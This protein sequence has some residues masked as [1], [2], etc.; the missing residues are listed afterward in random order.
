MQGIRKD[1]YG[2]TVLHGVDLEL[3]A[4]EIH[5]LLGENGAGKSTLMNI[6]FGMPVIHSTGGFTGSITLDGRPVAIGSPGQAMALGIGMVHQEF[7]LIPGFTVAENVKLNREPLRR[8]L[9]GRALGRVVGDSLD[10][11]DRARMRADTEA[12]LARIELPLDPDTP[13]A[14]L[15]VGHLQFIE[16][17][18]EVDKTGMRVL[19]FD[20]PTAVL[21]ESEASRLLAVMRSLADAGLAILFITHRLDE[22]MSVADRVTILRDGALALGAPRSELT[23]ERI[24]ET[25]V[26]RPIAARAAGGGADATGAVREVA[27]ILEIR[28]LAVE[29]PGE[30]VRGVSLEVRRGEILGIGGLAGQGKI[31]IANGVMGL[32]AASGS[33]RFEGRELPLGDPRGARAAGLAFVSEDRRGTGL[34]LDEPLAMNIA[35]PAM[36]VRGRFLRPRRPLPR[37]LRSLAFVDRAA[38]R[39]HAEGAIAELDIRTTGPDQPVR[40]LS[41]G[42]QQK[43][44]LAA[45]L[46]TEPRLLF[47]SEP[48]RGIDIGA[49]QLVLDRLVDLN[50]D[51]LTVVM[52][53]SELAELR[54]ICHRIAIVAEGRIAGI[55]PPDA[56]DVRFG[57][58]MAGGRT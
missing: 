18:R 57:L 20:E 4:G 24:A 13:V 11:L 48:T 25:M 42:N 23:I 22:V 15:P 7:M 51:G 3:R 53:S 52:T 16:I 45:A 28:D 44:C 54:T 40:R 55:L 26:G 58:L 49:K 21:A 32:F 50:R 34:L 39:A 10:T 46:G 9:A 6:L 31:G 30:R 29:M 5:A 27:P 47:V 36:E 38:V 19:V 8:G 43:V 2:T 35:V 14:G 1:Y 41:G 56:P 37:G 12:A 17:A 33:V